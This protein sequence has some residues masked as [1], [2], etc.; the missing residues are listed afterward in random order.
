M[1]IIE[2]TQKSS[3]NGGVP[4]PNIFTTCAN[5]NLFYIQINIIQIFKGGKTGFNPVDMHGLL[6]VY[7]H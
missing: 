1:L 4:L 5:Q 2:I 6:A 7:L 3:N